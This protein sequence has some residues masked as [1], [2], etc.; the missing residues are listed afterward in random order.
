MPQARSDLLR[1]S[2]RGLLLG[3]SGMG[4][5]ALSLARRPL[6]AQT[7]LPPMGT[8]VYS[9]F[10][11]GRGQIGSLSTDLA[12]AGD[13]VTATIERQIQVKVLGV[14]VYRNESRVVQQLKQ[15]RLISLTREGNDNGDKTSL[16]IALEGGGL[17]VE[18]AGETWSLAADLLPSS[19]WNPAVVT[20]GRLIDLDSGRAIEVTNSPEGESEVEVAGAKIQARK[21]RQNGVLDRDLWFDATG[22]LAHMVL[23][24]R[25]N[26]ITMVLER[27]PTG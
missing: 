18:M 14:T 27:A 12:D 19:P 15:G 16:K 1:P 11:E 25:G 3:I 2:R 21:T 8:Y 20:N 23:R 17:K 6:A 10:D 22:R 26:V 24:R 4:L 9:I 7:P 13:S 5:A